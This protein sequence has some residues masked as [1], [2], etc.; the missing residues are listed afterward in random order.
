MAGYTSTDPCHAVRLAVATAVPCKAGI[1]GLTGGVPLDT[2]L[3]G[4]Y[5]QLN[6]TAV[7]V[8]IA[9]LADSAGNAAS[10]LIT[11]ETTVD[12][13]WMPPSPILNSFAAF[14]F[15]ASVAALIVFT[16]HLPLCKAVTDTR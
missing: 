12:Y 3:Y 11:G 14:T 2:A 8:T 15:T 13:F 7:T 5:V 6:A 10:L 16:Y 9:G 4:V 1:L